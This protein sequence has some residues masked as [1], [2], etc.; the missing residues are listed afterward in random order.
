MRIIH[1]WNRSEFLTIGT[2]TGTGLK[3]LDR[4]G[5]AGVPVKPADRQKTVRLVKTGRPAINR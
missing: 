5:P 3:N 1:R 2:S 4:T